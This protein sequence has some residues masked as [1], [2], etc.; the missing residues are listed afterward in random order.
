MAINS[1]KAS[2]VNSSLFT[3]SEMQILFPSNSSP[4]L[5][6]YVANGIA[7]GLTKNEILSAARYLTYVQNQGY[8]IETF[9]GTTYARINFLSGTTS[10]NPGIF[11]N[12]SANILIVAGGGGGGATSGAPRNLAGSGGSGIVILKVNFT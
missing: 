4:A 5:F 8:T 7:T 6:N 12:A 11:N 1:S 9:S 2:I 3:R 10:F